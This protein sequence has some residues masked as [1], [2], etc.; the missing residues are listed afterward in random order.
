M[1]KT[2]QVTL[3][4]VAVN[5]VVTDLDAAWAQS[6]VLS[7]WKTIAATGEGLTAA[8][9]E[10][11]TGIG[12]ASDSAREEIYSQYG[13]RLM[14]RLIADANF[15][16]DFAEKL[17]QIFPSIPPELVAHRRVEQP[18]GNLIRYTLRI[19]ADELVELFTAILAP[20]QRSEDS[21]IAPPKANPDNTADLPPEMGNTDALGVAET[22][23]ADADDAADLRLQIA[24]LEQRLHTATEASG[25]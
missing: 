14:T 2:I 5:G 9:R 1:R 23:S 13:E 4:G 22:P 11:F 16:A 3:D 24:E 12:E 7:G 20:F 21:A 8:I 18:E 25:S 15:A 17:T 19:D 6:L 10:S